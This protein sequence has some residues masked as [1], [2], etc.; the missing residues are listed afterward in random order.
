MADNQEEDLELSDFEDEDLDAAPEVVS[1]SMVE[2][3]NSSE[4][5]PKASIDKPI[6]Q[7]PIAENDLQAANGEKGDTELER[8]LAQ[9][10]AKRDELERELQVERARA[11][12]AEKVLKATQSRQVIMI[13]HCSC[14]LY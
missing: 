4:E 6:I 13:T 7:A 12:E 1:S 2:A 10:R 11:E 14:S 5:P 9:E 8:A 3:V